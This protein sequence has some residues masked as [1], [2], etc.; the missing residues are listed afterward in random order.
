MKNIVAKCTQS[1]TYRRKLYIGLYEQ[2]R[3]LH[4]FLAG[5]VFRSGRAG[6]KATGPGR[7]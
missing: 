1:V 7:V 2:V 3:R 4:V 5:P 6:F